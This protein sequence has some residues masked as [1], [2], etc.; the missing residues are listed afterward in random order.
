MTNGFE[1]LPLT[2][3]ETKLVQLLRTNPKG[4]TSTEI[5]A[6]VYGKKRLPANS[7][8]IINDK[9]ARLTRKLENNIVAEIVI[10][11]TTRKGPYPI[12]YKAV[13]KERA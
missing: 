5:I 2:P 1:D 8:Q 7:R 13:E 9:L 10:V 4:M 12:M 11:K 3:W 6:A